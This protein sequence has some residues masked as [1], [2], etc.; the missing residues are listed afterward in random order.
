MLDKSDCWRELAERSI[1]RYREIEEASGVNFYHEVGFLSLID[2]QYKDTE[3][4]QRALAK[5]E[6]LG[7]KYEEI[8]DNT[9][10]TLLSCKCVQ[11]TPIF[12]FAIMMAY[13][14]IRYF[15]LSRNCR[16]SNFPVSI[17]NCDD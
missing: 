5:L 3:K 7:Y 9:R 8:R 13:F 11:N 6:S 2:D 14:P 16:W 10:L 15:C 17:T 4:L 12:H 1:L